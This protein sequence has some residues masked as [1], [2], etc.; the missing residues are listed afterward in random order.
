[1]LAA[2]DV[3][4]AF[5]YSGETDELL[6]ILPSVLRLSIPIIAFTGRPQSSLGRA[7]RVVLDVGVQK[8]ACL[9]NLAPTTST[10]VMLALGDAVAVAVMGAREFS[11]EEYAARH[12]AGSLGRRLLLRVQDI[13]RQGDAAAIVS[14]RA[15]LRDVLFAITRA[16]AGAAVVV[17]SDGI[18]VGLVTDGDARRTL[19]EDLQYWER[20]VSET[21]NRRFG[22][23][24]FDIP[25][26]ESLRLL[27]SFHPDPGTSVGEAP[28]VDGR[29]RPL[30]MLT[31]K[32]LVKS[33]IV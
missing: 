16:H 7:A 31:L 3:L 27:E 19:L 13:M 22:R 20:P 9:F 23:I 10:T 25:A 1:M 14:E 28:V 29:G 2:G 24:P 21:M 8:E 4:A 12:P 33:G 15:T 6:A 32:D 18:A 17:D 5:S 26:A 30:G 11:V